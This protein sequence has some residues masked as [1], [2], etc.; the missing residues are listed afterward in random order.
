MASGIIRAAAHSPFIDFDRD[1]SFILPG[2]P[3]SFMLT[4]MR[5]RID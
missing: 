1:M 3:V 4:G 2:W 5:W